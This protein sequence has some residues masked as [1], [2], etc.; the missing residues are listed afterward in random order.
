MEGHIPTPVA[1]APMVED[2]MRSHLTAECATGL[3]G[4]AACSACLAHR[5]RAYAPVGARRRS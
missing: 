5:L 4:G 1:T 3:D 2:L